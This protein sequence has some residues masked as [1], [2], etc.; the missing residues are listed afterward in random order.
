MRLFIVRH[1]KAEDRAAHHGADRD[2]RLTPRGVRQA[3]FLAHAVAPF[4]PQ[5]GRAV[6]SPVERA[7]QTGVILCD[8]LGLNPD[9]DDRLSTSF[10]IEE[11]LAVVGE[12]RDAGTRSGSRSALLIIGHN[13]TLEELVWWLSP[14][15]AQHSELRTGECV[16]FDLRGDLRRGCG[17]WVARLRLED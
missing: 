15:G 13:P 2:R 17:E 11:A 9:F 4:M 14:K 7:R 3:E 12:A 1:G 6:V 16:V 10:G 5:G 8:S